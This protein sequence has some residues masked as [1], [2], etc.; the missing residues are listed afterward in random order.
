MKRLAIFRII[1]LFYVSLNY[2]FL[3]Y[4]R[5]LFWILVFFFMI[6][7]GYW[8]INYTVSYKLG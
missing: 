2:Y 5:I 7:R 1:M 6:M 3:T 4:H 8:L